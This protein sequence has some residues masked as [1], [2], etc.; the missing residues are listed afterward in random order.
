[1]AWLVSGCDS[2][3]PAPTA[4][5]GE[6]LPGLTSAHIREFQAG[7]ALFQRTFSATEG[8]GPTFNEP[9]CVSCHDVPT[10]GGAGADDVR[11]AT[12]F[13][14]GRCNLLLEQGGDMFQTQ[15]TDALRSGGFGAEAV[16][17][18]ATVG[19]IVAPALYGAGLIEAVPDETILDRADPDDA[20]QDGISGRPGISSD[21]RVGRFGWKASFATITHFVQSALHGEMGLTTRAFPNESPIGPHSLPS[22]SDP[23]PDP[24]IDDTSVGELASF[25]RLLAP[26]ASDS[27]SAA[28]RDSIRE[29]RR[30][31]EQLGC[32]DCH[33]PEL[34]TRAGEVE[35]MSRKRVAL[36]SDLLLH[37]MGPEN[38]SICTSGAEPSEWR[39]AP[40]MGLHLR[41]R[42]WHDGRAHSAESAIRAHGGEAARARDQFM[43]LTEQ[44][45]AVLFS[46]LGS[47]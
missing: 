34:R 18:G 36:Y 46:F 24:E 23:T 32:D 15:V 8:L 47:L 7:R 26:A 19:L 9:R 20:N 14:N 40:L 11:K 17:R 30:V 41:V 37:D 13:D 21:G 33:R 22:G 35:P 31:F 38:A 4:A 27:A 25:V 10:I 45:R 1:L 12:R 43:V 5:P 42:Y 3:R 2:S 6:P 44:Q 39:T 28:A 29:G 16:P